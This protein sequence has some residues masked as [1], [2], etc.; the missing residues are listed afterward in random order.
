MIMKIYQFKEKK[1][2]LDREK[3]GTKFVART[4]PYKEEKYD[5]LF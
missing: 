3:K 2:V 4:K 1:M 5:K